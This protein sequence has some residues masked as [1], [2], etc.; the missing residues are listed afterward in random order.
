MNGSGGQV[1]TGIVGIVTFVVILFLLFVP[2][3]A[4]YKISTRKD[5]RRST[6]L[7]DSETTQLV[8]SPPVDSSL[9]KVSPPIA[10]T[11]RPTLQ[12]RDS[13]IRS[14]F[15]KTVAVKYRQTDDI[16]R[17]PKYDLKYRYNKKTYIM[18]KTESNFYKRLF[19]IFGREFLIFPQIH[20]P[21]LFFHTS[22]RQ[23]NRASLA[24][25]QRKSVDYVLCDVDMKIYCAIELDDSSH[26]EDD[27][28]ERDKF[29]NELFRCARQPLVRIS[30]RYSLSDEEIRRLV[31][32]RVAQ[33]GQL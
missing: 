25:I 5:K 28:I 1:D 30:T 27:R 7:P 26:D 6:K 32:E 16:L 4:I 12:K 31:A 24:K 21:S 15:R 10:Q 2:F 18:T 29:V 20:L 9:N 22:Y 33:Y 19:G 8:D 17:Y 11:P 14:E 23:D 13:T 3:W